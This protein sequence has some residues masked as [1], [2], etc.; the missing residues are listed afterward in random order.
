MHE[1]FTSMS[2]VA[3]VED[4]FDFILLVIVVEGWARTC[5]FASGESLGVIGDCRFQEP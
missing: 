5:W 4:S 3:M 1:E 2:S